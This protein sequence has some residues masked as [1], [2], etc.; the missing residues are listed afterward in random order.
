MNVFLSLQPEKWFHNSK[1]L[2][3]HRKMS[4]QDLTFE[5]NGA[6]LLNI[7]NGAIL[8]YLINEH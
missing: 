2:T 5:C 7:N 1:I 8:L 4:V 3:L 6:K